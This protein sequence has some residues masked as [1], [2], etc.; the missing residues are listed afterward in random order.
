[1]IDDE[2][3]IRLTEYCFN[4][5]ETLKGALHGK[6]PCDLSESEKMGVQNLDRC[7]D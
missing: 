5:C 2:H 3:A 4:A 6:N 7:V 1:M